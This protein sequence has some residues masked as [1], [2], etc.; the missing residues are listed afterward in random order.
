MQKCKIY[1]F[2]HV[3]R[4]RKVIIVVIQL[5]VFIMIYVKVVVLKSSLLIRV[6]FLNF[7]R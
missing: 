3:P 1:P 5:L 4:G 7:M 2:L 6:L